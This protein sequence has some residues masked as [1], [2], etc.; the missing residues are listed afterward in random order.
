MFSETSDKTSHRFNLLE[1]RQKMMLPGARTT[2]KTSKDFGIRRKSNE[3]AMKKD[4]SESETLQDVARTTTASLT[5]DHEL[6]KID[7]NSTSNSG[8]LNVGVEKESA[9]LQTNRIPEDPTLDR[10]LIPKLSEDDK[11]RK[12]GTMLTT[13]S[14]VELDNGC[15]SKIA[16]SKVSLVSD[17]Y[18]DT[19]SDSSK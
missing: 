7:L 4:C 1:K 5:N 9:G 16:G 2:R 13:S 18:S 19:D 12:C 11:P 15:Q 8:E 6:S 17:V 3:N 14:D 10:V